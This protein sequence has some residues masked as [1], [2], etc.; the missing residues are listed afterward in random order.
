MVGFAT[1]RSV[2]RS[3]GALLLA[4]TCLAQPG[5]AGSGTSA[6]AWPAEI[7]AARGKGVRPPP[8]PADPGQPATLCDAAIRA[9]EFRHLLPAGLLFAIGQV[10]S[11]RPD[12]SLRRLEPWPWT[13]QAEGRSL[14]FETKTQAVAWVKAAEARGVTSID[15]GCLQVNLAYHPDAFAT[16]EDAFDPQRNADFAARFLVQLHAET[17]DWRQATGFYHSQTLLLATAYR[18]R[19]GRALGGGTAP[20]GL[21]LAW[22]APKPPTMLDR[23]GAAWRATLDDTGA[24][25]VPPPRATTGV[26]MH[27]WSALLRRSP[28]VPPPSS[29]PARAGRKRRD[30]DQTVLIP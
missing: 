17:G 10:E 20:G 6:D 22:G 11:G 26:A 9:A 1:P 2:R 30:A 21:G 18:E 3:L 13:V 4:C 27:D 29:L 23:L 12:P 8:V 19:I 5:W 7:A 28:H 14:Y 15:T 25:P 16:P 24:A